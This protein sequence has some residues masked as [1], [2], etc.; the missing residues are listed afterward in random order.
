MGRS[1]TTRA[2]R[3]LTEKQ[4][5][6]VRLIA[7]GVSNREACR[8]VGV[9]RR[10]GTRW[11]LG[12]TIRNSAG[13]AVHYPPV[14]ILTPPKRHP[15]YLSLDERMVI[16]DLRRER[17][18]VREIAGELGRSPA[19]VSR[20]LRRNVD[21]RGRYLPRSA[22]RAATERIARPRARR[23]MVDPELRAV[24]VDLLG[25]VESGTGRARAAR[26]VRRPACPAPMRSSPEDGGRIA[27]HLREQFLDARRGRHPVV[28]VELQIAVAPIQRPQPRALRI[29]QS[30]DREPR[31]LRTDVRPPRRAAL[32]DRQMPLGD[33][34]LNPNLVANMLR[35]PSATPP[36]H[37][38]NI[39]LRQTRHTR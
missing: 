13:E 16:A 20:E 35:N 24:V 18:S 14:H 28:L 5:R 26:T 32:H 34:R 29:A 1:R 21:D 37:P 25:T 36:L 27:V 33:I 6:F 17:R 7:Q 15:R 30:R 22:D 38:S 10:T 12:R 9:N 19:T 23:V 11:R 8:I 4:N 2:G 39:R 31:P 3:A